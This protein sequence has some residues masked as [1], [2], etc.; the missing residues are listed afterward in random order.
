MFA[1]AW[2]LTTLGVVQANEASAVR[3]STKGS[4][5]IA[6]VIEMLQN[7]KGKIIED[8]KEERTDMEE[9]FEYCD[10]EK[11]DKQYAIKTATSKIED[12]AAAI[13]QANGQI[14]ELNNEIIEIS[15][16][17]AD[18]QGEL[19]K[20]KELRD[21]SHEEFKKREHE[22]EVMIGELEQMEYALK[23]Q[24]LAMTTPP[25]VEFVQGGE[26]ALL[27]VHHDTAKVPD[28]AALGL[29][30]KDIRHTLELMT[31]TVNALNL[32]PEA[33]ALFQERGRDDYEGDD[34][35]M[36]PFDEVGRMRK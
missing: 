22:Q 35:Y 23:H 32:D 6:K 18:K 4:N 1:V 29:N 13:E 33:K 17:I 25:P 7:E 26:E 14:E 12:L 31:R 5:V 19:D 9:Y 10:T 15:G 16:D 34:K 27:Q 20:A 2:L 3:S 11:S 21:Q 30:T 28:S 24:M 36:V 8:L